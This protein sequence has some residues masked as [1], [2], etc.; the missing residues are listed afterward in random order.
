MRTIPHINNQL[1]QLDEIVRT[2]FIT[3]ISGENC[4]RFLLNWEEIDGI[5]IFS[6]TADREYTLLRMI[7]EELTIKIINQH[8]T[9]MQ[10]RRI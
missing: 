4:C 6:E 8:Q 3:E 10:M 7:S 1:K 9:Q 2:E 5:P